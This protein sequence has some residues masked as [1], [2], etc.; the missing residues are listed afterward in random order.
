MTEST[1]GRLI[2]IRHGDTPKPNEKKWP[3]DNT[4]P[5]KKKGVK[6][7]KKAAAGLGTLIKPDRVIT[8]PT[9]RTMQTAEILGWD[10]ECWPS[11][12]ADQVLDTGTPADVL[13]MVRKLDGWPCTVALVGHG[14]NLTE[15]AHYLVLGFGDNDVPFDKGGAMLVNVKSKL[16]AGSGQLRW[17]YTQKEL[18][19]HR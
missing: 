2:L 10:A 19:N 4:R 9:A 17:F 5:L 11:A 14:P 13:K 15:L 12:T 8:S 1:K 3:E 6:R 7:F 18:K 16:K